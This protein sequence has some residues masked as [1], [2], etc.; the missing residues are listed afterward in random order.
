MGTKLN[1]VDIAIVEYNGH[2]YILQQYLHFCTSEVRP[3]FLASAPSVF[4]FL[5]DM[6]LIRLKLLS[7]CLWILFCTLLCSC[8]PL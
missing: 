1:R 7:R 6:I 3:R 2:I 8:M 4:V 5:F